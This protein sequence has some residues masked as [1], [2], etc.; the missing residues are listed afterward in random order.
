MGATGMRKLEDISLPSDD[1]AA[2]TEAARLLRRHFPVERVVL[3]GSKARNEDDPESDIDL[4]VVTSRKLKWAEENE[5]TRA[6]YPLQL[7]YHV[8][9]SPVIVAKEEWDEGVYRV[10]PIHREIERDG[11]AA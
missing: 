2:I 4:L 1:R 3:F 5:I 8:A 10:L 6:L 7:Q 11:V 9:L